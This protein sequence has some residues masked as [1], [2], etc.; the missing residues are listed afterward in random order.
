MLRQGLG[1]I[2]SNQQH[3]PSE[4]AP[5]VRVV[6]LHIMHTKYASC[7]LS[8]VAHSPRQFAFLS[9]CST[10]VAEIHVCLPNVSL[11]LHTEQVDRSFRDLYSSI[12]MFRCCWSPANFRSFNIR[13]QDMVSDASCT[14]TSLTAHV[15]R[16]PQ[17]ALVCKMHGN[18]TE[19]AVF[20]RRLS[21]QHTRRPQVH[22]GLRVRGLPQSWHHRAEPR[23]QRA[24]PIRLRCRLLRRL[25]LLQQPAGL[26]KRR[27]GDHSGPPASTVKPR[28]DV[29]KLF[30]RSTVF[31]SLPAGEQAWNASPSPQKIRGIT[32]T[33][34]PANHVS[35]AGAV[36]LSFGTDFDFT[37]C[38]LRSNVS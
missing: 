12:A 25:H 10:A 14:M 26:W 29:T 1:Q 9:F 20:V 30:W 19:T 34:R 35:K 7:L 28:P 36:E 37:V 3:A 33:T 31:A 21:G 15:G 6:P 5:D 24:G 4:Q 8:P 32:C 13:R 2:S 22:R 38:L 23:E 16:R 27:V 11:H 18:V 17:V